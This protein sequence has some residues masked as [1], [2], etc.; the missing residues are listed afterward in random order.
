MAQNSLPVAFTKQYEADVHEAYQRRGSKLRGLVRTKTGVR[1][2]TIQFPKFGRGSA[3]QKSRHGEIVPM[4][5]DHSNVTAT[6]EDWYAGAWNDKLDDLKHNLNE[7]QLLI[8]TGAYALGRKSDELITNALNSASGAAS[9]GDGTTPLTKALVLEGFKRL[10]KRDIP[11][12]GRR[13][14]IVG[15]DQW[16][17]LLQIPEFADADYIS[18]ANLPW[19]KGTQVKAWLGMWWMVF[20]GL[21]ATQED[22]GIRSNFMFHGDA[23]GHAIQQEIISDITWHGDRASWFINNMMAQGAV[24]IDELAVVRINTKEA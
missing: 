22:G 11:D 8:N 13:F 17:D 1:G 7:R 24:L 18:D 15:A 2:A 10:N 12:D 19:L 3:T 9:I 20:T 23:V 16:N 21:P 5:P 6:L 14:A 4:N